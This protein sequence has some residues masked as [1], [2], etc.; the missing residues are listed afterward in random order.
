MSL[1]TWMVTLGTAATLLAVGQPASAQD[2]G[3]EAS[4]KESLTQEEKKKLLE[5]VK[6][7]REEYNA[8]NF[9]EAVPLFEQAYE[10]SKKPELHYRIALSHENAGNPKKAVEYYE[11]FLEARPETDKRGKIE[12]TLERLKK[13]VESE[14]KAIL[15]IESTPSRAKVFLGD[16]DQPEGTTPLEVRTQPG[17]VRIRLA[18]EGRSEV[19][20]TVDVEAGNDYN[21][22]YSLPPSNG[23]SGGGGGGGGLGTPAIVAGIVGITGAVVGGTFY[24]IALYCDDNRDACTRELFFSS[25]TASWIGAGIG[26]AGLSTATVLALTGNGGGDESARRL[27]LRITPR[28]VSLTGPL[29]KLFPNK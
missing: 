6:A 8:G 16:A 15:E 1:R 17:D 2:G 29:P 10:I 13:R 22:S 4:E 26:L 3:A 7:G 25:L 27:D 19:T 5:F 20:E 14:S 21:Y 24:G 28:S 12:A 23:G 9:E 11:K 18:K